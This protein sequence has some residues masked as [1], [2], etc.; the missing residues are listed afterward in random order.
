MDSKRRRS[1]RKPSDGCADLWMKNETEIRRSRTMG[2]GKYRNFE[3]DY[4]VRRKWTARPT[5]C[6]VYLCTEGKLYKFN[7]ISAKCFNY[8]PISTTLVKNIFPLQSFS[9]LQAAKL[10]FKE[11]LLFDTCFE[12]KYHLCVYHWVG[13]TRSH[14]LEGLKIICLQ[15]KFEKKKWV[16]LLWE[17]VSN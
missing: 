17:A 10:F 9:F 2:Q 12:I 15:H 16:T 6:I 4:E 1:W 14:N 7:D 13:R 11:I 8:V 5:Y 3:F